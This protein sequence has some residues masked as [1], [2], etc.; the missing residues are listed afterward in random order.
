[1]KDL[2]VNS[3]I[4]LILALALFSRPYIVL[5]FYYWLTFMV[6]Y[7]LVWSQIGARFVLISFVIFIIKYT[8]L[9]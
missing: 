3:N 6:P 5:L 7:K 1:M 4:L 2:F 9:L 8:R